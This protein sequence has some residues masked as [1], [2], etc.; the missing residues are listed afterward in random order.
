MATNGEDANVAAAYMD[1]LQP[2]GDQAS[3]DLAGSQTELEGVQ[4]E[5]AAGQARLRTIGNV[6]DL[7]PKADAMQPGSNTAS[8]S[9]R[10]VEEVRAIQAA[11][12]WD[13]NCRPYY[14]VGQRPADPESTKHPAREVLLYQPHETEGLYTPRMAVATLNAEDLAQ[15]EAL[16]DRLRAT[17]L[18]PEEIERLAD[19]LGNIVVNLFSPGSIAISFELHKLRLRPGKA[20][21]E[22]VA[23]YGVR[24]AELKHGKSGGGD[25]WPWYAPLPEWG[26][27]AVEW[28]TLETVKHLGGLAVLFGKEAELQQVLDPQAPGASAEDGDE[29]IPTTS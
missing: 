13:V 7:L 26:L 16:I 28:E 6:I 17:E 23:E 9:A 15:R 5:I 24:K 14:V 29:S 27:N 25:L 3:A 18:S 20:T 19:K 8:L 4:A 21:P 1:A 12:L 11:T 10:S 22:T 2:W